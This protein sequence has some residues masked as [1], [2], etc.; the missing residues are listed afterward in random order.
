MCRRN[1]AGAV[2]RCDAASSALLA[3]GD[4]VH[5]R[6]LGG[7]HLAGIVESGNAPG[8]PLLRGGYPRPGSTVNI[9]FGGGISASSR[10]G[11]ARN[12]VR[13]HVEVAGHGHSAIRHEVARPFTVSAV[14]NLE[15]G[16]GAISEVYGVGVHRTGG[17]ITA[18]LLD[19][20]NAH[21]RDALYALVARVALL[22]LRYAKRQ[23]VFAVNKRAGSC[24]VSVRPK[25]GNVQLHVY[26]GVTGGGGSSGGRAGSGRRPRGG[27][28]GA[29]SSV[30][31][32]GGIVSFLS[33]SSGAVCGI[34]SAARSSGCGARRSG[35]T[36]LRF[37]GSFLRRRFCGASCFRA[38]LRAASGIAGVGLAL[39]SR[40]LCQLGGCLCGFRGA[41]SSFGSVCGGARSGSFSVYSCKR[42]FE[43]FLSAGITALNGLLIGRRTVVALRPLY[44]L[45]AVAEVGGNDAGDLYGRFVHL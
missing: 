45:C 31:A 22:A 9:A 40:G 20:G 37:L 29:G 12:F 41:L 38:L 24:G 4:I 43:L 16:R 15:S 42:F 44:E 27:S 18:R 30:R 19:F 5:A 34:G 6:Q 1:F 8:L 32:V 23:D 36:A 21:T 10:S 25:R 33:R 26:N 7:G 14:I 2:K 28:C 39:C 3:V 13:V 17:M 11:D 35:S